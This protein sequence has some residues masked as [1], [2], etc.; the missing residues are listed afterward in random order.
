MSFT[1]E[2]TSIS[3]ISITTSAHYA[4]ALYNKNTNRIN[5]MIYS[6]TSGTVDAFVTYYSLS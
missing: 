2:G 1:P 6:T 5:C 3:D 4:S